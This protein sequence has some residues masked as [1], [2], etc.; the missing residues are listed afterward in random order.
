ME[1]IKQDY[2]ASTSLTS[3]TGTWADC[4]HANGI[5]F[6]VDFWIFRKEMFW[7][8]DCEMPIPRKVAEKSN[9]N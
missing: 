2:T 3:Y 1:K 4:K 5:F 7:C 6:P 9:E 8:Y